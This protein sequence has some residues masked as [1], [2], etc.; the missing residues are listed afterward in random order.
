MFSLIPQPSTTTKKIMRTSILHKEPGPS[1][2]ALRFYCKGDHPGRFS[3]LGFVLQEGIEL[4]EWR[5]FPDKQ[6]QGFY[7]SASYFVDVDKSVIDEPNRLV[8]EH[9]EVIRRRRQAS[10]EI[11]NMSRKDHSGVIKKIS[12]VL[13]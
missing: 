13:R 5:S 11:S 4:S 2:L 7:N 12:L 1:R 3:A 10:A 8:H 6:F 9:E